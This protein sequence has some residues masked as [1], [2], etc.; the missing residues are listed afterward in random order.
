MPSI[1][2]TVAG[3]YFAVFVLA[4]LWNVITDV[5]SGIAAVL[6][7]RQLP[8]DVP[9]SEPGI[10]V[11]LVHGTWARRTSWTVRDSPLCKTLLRAADA[12]VLFQRFVWSGRN[13][14]SARRGAVRG[15]VEHLHSVIG[16]W[17]NARHY[18]VAHS[19]GGNVAF[20]ALGDPVLN[21]RVRGLV[22]LSTPFL[23]VMRRD[24]GPIGQIALWW[25]PVLLIFYGGMFALQQASFSHIDALGVVLLV[26]A[27][28]SGFLTSRLLNRLSTS[29]LESL[30]YPAVDPS[31]ILILRAAGDEASAALAAT[32]IVSWA[33]GRLWLTTSHALGRTV[34]T[35]EH[36]R[37]TLTRHR[38]TTTLVIGCLALVLA[39]SFLTWSSTGVPAWL[40]PIVPLAGLS[41]LLMVAT[42]FRGGLMAA[43][44]GRIM[45]AA[46]AAPF[47][48]L[49]AV[50]GASLGP[51]LLAAGLLFQVTA[52]ATPPGRWVVWQVAASPNDGDE[53]APTGLMHS[54]SY[55]N[56]KALEI[57]EA[58]FATATPACEADGSRPRT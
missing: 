47:L 33:A 37:G 54:A 38:L 8:T 7:A 29:V 4:L 50:F 3:A 27:V 41:L 34:D 53:R 52:E 28:A 5:I 49:I 31:K 2:L 44:L 12:P 22:C 20:Q 9:S 15:L 39:V 51:E 16:Q 1:A 30:E 35:V 18:V 40:Q 32:H 17:P 46:V 48:M 45:F 25:L 43:L 26:L 55:Q 42:L 56:P 10:V 13:S 36:W 21:E 19:H 57:L 24:L 58:W 11:T 23:T 14:I 6:R